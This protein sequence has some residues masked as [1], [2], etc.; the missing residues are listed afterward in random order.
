MVARK[1][2][3]GPVAQPGDAVVTVVDG[4]PGA[5]FH[6]E[7]LAFFRHHQEQHPVDE[8]EQLPVVARLV[9]GSVAQR[10]A[11][12]LV[13]G[14]RGEGVAQHPERL[15]HPDAELLPD[16]AALFDPPVV[17]VLQEAFVRRGLAEGEPGRV[18]EPVEDYELAVGVALVHGLYI[19]LQVGGFGEPGA[20]AQQAQAAAVGRHPPQSFGPVEE[21]LDLG[22][23]AAPVP[24]PPIVEPLVERHDM[25]GG[26]VLSA[27]DA[28]RDG[29]LGSARLDG[30][31]L[32]LEGG[33]PEQ[34]EELG[35]PVLPGEGGTAF[36]RA[37][38][39]PAEGVP[40]DPRIGEGP[41]DLLR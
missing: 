41:L 24:R 25:D 20:V 13:A 9:E 34:L 12:G 33:E 36:P 11:Q 5:R 37:F 23:G 29:E 32:V 19:E 28:V 1:V 7:K 31:P 26:G 38:E 39:P 40:V 18:H 6:E 14:M 30:R 2:L 4:L 27:V 22:V 3:L 21:V 15:L 16:P 8:V 35:G 17:V 10:G